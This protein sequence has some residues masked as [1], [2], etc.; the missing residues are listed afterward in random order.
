MHILPHDIDVES[1]E[2]LLE[3]IQVN[4]H[5]VE[6]EKLLMILSTLIIRVILPLRQLLLSTAQVAII[7]VHAFL[8]GRRVHIL[9]IQVV[10]L[11]LVPPIHHLLHMHLLLQ[12]PVSFELVRTQV[13]FEV[14]GL[15]DAVLQSFLTVQLGVPKSHLVII[16]VQ[17]HHPDSVLLCLLVLAETDEDSVLY[18]VHFGLG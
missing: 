4:H 16:L 14:L 9:V 17:S 3:I 8:R 7:L 18:G 2:L 10:L 1:F 5:L 13:K 12:A 6:S 11:E 15:A